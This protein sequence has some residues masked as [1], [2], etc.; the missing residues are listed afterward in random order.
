MRCCQVPIAESSLP[1]TRSVAANHDLC[2]TTTTATMTFVRSVEK[3]IIRKR[4]VH[5]TEE[6]MKQN[7]NISTYMASSPNKR[8]DIVPEEVPKPGAKVAS[9]AIK[10][11][12]SAQIKD[13]TPCILYNLMCTDARRRLSANQPPRSLTVCDVIPSGLLLRRHCAEAREAE[14]C[15]GHCYKQCRLLCACRL[16]RYHSSHHIPD[17]QFFNFFFEFSRLA[18]LVM[19]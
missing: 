7:P 10:E 8:Q 11:W 6:M 9:A 18:I 17:K 14:S 3:S 4:Y 1:Q 19:A 12:G 15:Q 13:D 5:L 16:M 2:F